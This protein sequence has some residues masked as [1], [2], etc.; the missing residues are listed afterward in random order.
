MLLFMN[1]GPSLNLV[2]LT[3]SPQEG[4]KEGEKV[5]AKIV[6]KYQSC[7]HAKDKNFI[8]RYGEVKNYYR[9]CRISIFNFCSF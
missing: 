8:D 3:L 1:S 6:T 4:Q 5:T 7:F 2:T 9:C